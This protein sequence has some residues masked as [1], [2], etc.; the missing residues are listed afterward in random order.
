MQANLQ[1]KNHLINVWASEAKEL[2]EKVS[3]YHGAEAAAWAHRYSSV[4]E[5]IVSSN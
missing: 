5:A 3:M 4:H 2:V 1:D